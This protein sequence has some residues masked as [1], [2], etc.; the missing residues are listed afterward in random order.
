M[1]FAP[2]SLTVPTAA[3]FNAAGTGKY[4][5]STVTFG[6]PNNLLL[7]TGAKRNKSG[8]TTAQISRTIQKDVVV[9]T[10]TVRKSMTVRLVLEVQDG[11]TTTEI[12]NSLRQIDEFASV[13]NLER[14]LQGEA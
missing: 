8:L 6:Q 13:A 12:D 3:T 14:I 9:G 10:A 1:P 4:A 7:V 5:L 2:I 11:F